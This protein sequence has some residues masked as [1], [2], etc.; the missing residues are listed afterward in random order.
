MGFARIRVKYDFVI[1]LFM[2]ISVE[3]ISKPHNE[4]QN[5]NVCLVANLSLTKDQKMLP[6]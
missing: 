2:N 3:F 1:V 4:M 5:T 6:I